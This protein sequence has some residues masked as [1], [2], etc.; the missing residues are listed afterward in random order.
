MGPRVTLI[1]LE[2]LYSYIYQDNPTFG[3]DYCI[4]VYMLDWR[5]GKLGDFHYRCK[6]SNKIKIFRLSS[7]IS[8]RGNQDW[9]KFIEI[10]KLIF[11]GSD[12]LTGFLIS[13]K[14]SISISYWFI[15]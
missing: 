15:I 5:W 6:G 7:W 12:I 10:G 4:G 11:E 9:I 3:S 13:I 14:P 1:L 2:S 8:S